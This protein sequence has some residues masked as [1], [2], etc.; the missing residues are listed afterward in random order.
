LPLFEDSSTDDSQPI[1]V[2]LSLLQ[3]VVPLLIDVYS[4]ETSSTLSLDIIDSLYDAH[5]VVHFTYWALPI[6][7]CSDLIIDPATF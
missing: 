7:G 4:T 3:F 1:I 6:P 5:M 2:D